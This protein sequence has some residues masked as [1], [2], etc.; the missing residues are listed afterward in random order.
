MSGS[1]WMEAGITACRR[2]KRGKTG[3]GR[4][5]RQ[6]NS[7]RCRRLVRTKVYYYYALG[8]GCKKQFAM[9]DAIPGYNSRLPDPSR[10][11]LASVFVDGLLQAPNTYV[12]KPGKLSFISEESPPDGA[13]I[14]AQFIAIYG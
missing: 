7:K 2:G 13:R 6:Y 10:L 5:R 9:S 4:K 11:S 3:K 8:D 1:E 12:L 14:I